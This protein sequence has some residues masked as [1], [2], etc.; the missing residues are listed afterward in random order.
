[1]YWKPVYQFIRAYGPGAEDAEDLTQEFFAKILRRD[2]LRISDPGKGR[3]RSLLS[4]ALRN[5]LVN[6]REHTE[7]RKRGGG[8]RKVEPMVDDGEAHLPASVEPS[9]DRW[10]DRQWALGLLDRVLMRLG[11]EYER[12]GRADVFAALKAS[13]STGRTDSDGF[14]TAE[15]ARKLDLS[16]GAVRVATHRLRQRYRDLL[17]AELAQT[18]GEDVSVEEEL[19]T[20]LQS[21]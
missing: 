18:V 5:F 16:P 11:S 19:R 12:S 7:A 3:L 10:F 1:M 4:A 20:L 8:W 21:V 14:S 6:A 17:L 13:I 9:P 15:V 2:L